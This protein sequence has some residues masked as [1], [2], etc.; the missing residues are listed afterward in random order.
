MFWGPLL[1]KRSKGATDNATRFLSASFGLIC[2]PQKSLPFD[3][4]FTGSGQCFAATSKSEEKTREN[5]RRSCRDLRCF[6]QAA[7]DASAN[8]HTA[9]PH[10]AAPHQGCRSCYH[11]PKKSYP[12]PGNE[13]AGLWFCPTSVVHHGAGL[14]PSHLPTLR[15]AVA[16]RE[17]HGRASLLGRPSGRHQKTWGAVQGGHR[18]PSRVCHKGRNRSLLRAYK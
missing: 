10:T 14:L 4:R 2:P 18:S 17:W 1:G 7:C 8:Q 15:S 12:T 11:A 16:R 6:C 5:D 3:F 9:S 13:I